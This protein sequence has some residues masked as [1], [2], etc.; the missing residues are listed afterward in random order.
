VGR[1]QRAV[2]ARLTQAGQAGLLLGENLLAVAVDLAVDGAGSEGL[3]LRPALELDGTAG[4]GALVLG[5]TPVI[6]D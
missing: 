4:L 5:Y 6:R 2:P 3:L 1:R